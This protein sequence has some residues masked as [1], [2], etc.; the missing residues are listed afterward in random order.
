MEF[1]EFVVHI[2]YVCVLTNNYTRILSI[3]SKFSVFF[4]ISI[5]IWHKRK[6]YTY[7]TIK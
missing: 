2:E 3:I 5:V 7:L 4:L 6:Y 1:G